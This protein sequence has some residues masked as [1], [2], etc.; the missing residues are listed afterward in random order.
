[1]IINVQ[2]P[3]YNF[4][5]I[6]RLLHYS[7]QNHLGFFALDISFS[8]THYMEYFN[9]RSESNNLTK[10]N[11]FFLYFGSLHLKYLSDQEKNQ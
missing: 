7:W 11:D 3:K 6:F 4:S 2:V 10:K 5:F 8:L 1:M 9:Q